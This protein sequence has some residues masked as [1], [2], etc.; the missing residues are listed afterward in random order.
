MVLI[1][2]LIHLGVLVRAFPAGTAHPQL[3]C[4]STS[5]QN[6]IMSDSRQGATRIVLL[7]S[8]GPNLDV[9]H[10]RNFCYAS[11]L[12]RISIPVLA[13]ADPPCRRIASH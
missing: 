12:L 10:H 2:M 4:R 7:L 3:D 6:G 1:D 5:L 8:Q 11:L 13:G 9:L